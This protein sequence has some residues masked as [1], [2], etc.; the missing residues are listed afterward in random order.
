MPR[1]AGHFVLGLLFV[2]YWAK[3]VS[4]AKCEFFICAQSRALRSLVP[5]FLRRGQVAR[6]SRSGAGG[7]AGL[8]FS[9]GF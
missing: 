8:A 7:A 2:L 5:S 9:M 4:R 3:V 1:N 6:L